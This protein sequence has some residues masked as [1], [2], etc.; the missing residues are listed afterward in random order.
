MYQQ[1]NDLIGWIT[2]EDTKIDYPV[3]FTKGEDYY[4]RRDFYKKKSTGG[5]LYINK[6]QTMEP[7]D[8]N[9]IIHGHNMTSNGT[10]FHDLLNYKKESYYETHKKIIYYTLEEREEYEIISVFLSK[11]YKVND[12][13]FKYYKFYG[14]Q[15]ES[16]HKNYIDNVKELA[17]YD[18][19][20]TATYPEKLITLSTC[21]YSQENGRLVVVAKQVS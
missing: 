12:N 1:N 17:L 18:T 2:I 19:G 21:E 6:H 4:L 11:V 15:S 10:M 3:M 13:V 16:D 5:T 20:I 14:E 9:I 8:I 7:R